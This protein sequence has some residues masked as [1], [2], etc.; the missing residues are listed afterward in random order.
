M[1][2]GLRPFAQ[3]A[4]SH[5]G[6]DLPRDKFVV[7]IAELFRLG[8]FARSH[9]DHLVKNLAALLL[10]GDA[11]EDVAA[12]DVHVLFLAAEGVV[13]GGELDRRRRLEA[14]GGPATGGEGDDVAARGDLAGDADRI[15]AGRIH[16]NETARADRLG[17]VIDAA[18]RRRAALRRR[19]ER[20]F[21]DRGKTA[22]LVAG[23]GIVVH[24]AMIARRIVLP[25]LD[26]GDE[27]LADLRGGSAA[28]E[29]V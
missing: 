12:V 23:R 3:P 14:E 7:A 28:G 19:P 13:V 9:R 1:G 15:I 26:D 11:V 25:P 20:F 24:L 18:E 8:A 29:E 17:I 16:E 5:H 4:A 2:T 22:R 21:E 27:L 6:A 10:D